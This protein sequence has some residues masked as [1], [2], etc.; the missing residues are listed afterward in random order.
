M[1]TTFNYYFIIIT[2]YT[3]TDDDVTVETS[4]FFLKL[5]VRLL[6]FVFYN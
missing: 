4:L 2:I 6:N 3:Y 5:F 1:K